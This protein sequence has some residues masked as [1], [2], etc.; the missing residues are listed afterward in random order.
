MGYTLDNIYG[1]IYIAQVEYSE[2]KN[3]RSC[4]NCLTWT[5]GVAFFFLFLPAAF[6]RSIDTEKPKRIVTAP[7]VWQEMQDIQILDNT[8]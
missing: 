1:Y 5:T 4:I 3:S 6:D 2:E 8:Y 7:K